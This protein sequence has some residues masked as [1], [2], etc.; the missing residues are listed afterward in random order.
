MPEPDDDKLISARAALTELRRADL[1]HV[2]VEQA[3][4]KVATLARRVIPGASE[5]SVTLITNEVPGTPTATSPLALA[6][7]LVQYRAEH[8]PCLTAADEQ[9]TVAV[10]IA[11]D[12]M[13]PAFTELAKEVGVR[14][15]LSVG[16]PVGPAVLGALNVYSTASDAFGDD[17]RELAETFAG[18][19][20]VALANAHLY[21][22]TAQVARQLDAA[23]ATRAVIEQAKGMIMLA[24][25]VSADEAFEILSTAS[26]RQN[27]KL[28][29]MA[30]MIVDGEL[31]VP[32]PQDLTTRGP[33]R[34]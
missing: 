30:Q 9:S 2:D 13:W 4:A 18:Y 33:D 5:V 22:S 16:L 15:S 34:H 31:P 19:T 8:G 10:C 3:L 23:M 1:A 27:R 28:R 12:K 7:D 24:R 26:Q 25:K 32:N 6:M 11:T 20:A 21:A 29:A 14:S 17:A